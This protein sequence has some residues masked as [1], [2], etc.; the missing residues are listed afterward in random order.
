MTGAFVTAGLVLVLIIAAIV[1]ARGTGA[2]DQ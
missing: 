1:A 2:D